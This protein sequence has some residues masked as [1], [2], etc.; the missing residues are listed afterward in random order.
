L[1]LISKFYLF[2]IFLNLYYRNASKSTKKP[3][4]NCT[5]YCV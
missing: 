4:K 2:P 1:K 3:K 5:R